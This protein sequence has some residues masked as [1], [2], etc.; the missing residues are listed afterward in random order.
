MSNQFDPE[1]Q[2]GEK[3]K[4][5]DTNVNTGGGTSIGGGVKTDGG[6]FVG[7][8]K[9]IYIPGISAKYWIALIV[10]LVIISIIGVSG[11]IL[12]TQIEIHS[13]QTAEVRHTASALIGTPNA[14]STQLSTTSTGTP[15]INLEITKISEHEYEANWN[16]LPPRDG[17]YYLVKKGY[18][19]YFS[20]EEIIPGQTSMNLTIGPNIEKVVIIFAANGDQD[21][22]PEQFPDDASWF[23]AISVA[24]VEH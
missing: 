8:D 23:E 7:R 6:D 24:I 9:N 16:K 2:T 11:K 19:N 10:T 5:G 12:P 13:T 15:N 21:H 20:P 3:A 14:L 17:S 1:A 18:D 22:I 4:T